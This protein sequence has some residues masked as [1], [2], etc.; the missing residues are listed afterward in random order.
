MEIFIYVIAADLKGPVKIGFS[1]HPEKRL[2][3]LQTGV[4]TP[5][6]LHHVQAFE[7]PRA[8][9]IEKMLHKT[10]RIQRQKGEWF[11]LSVEEAILEV[12]FA[13]IRYGEDPILRHLL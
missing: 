1:K 9:L 13:T 7:A 4:P 5:L 8:K 12:E 2:R 6:T 10:L 3:E 11:K